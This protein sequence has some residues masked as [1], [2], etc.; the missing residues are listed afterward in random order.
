[1]MLRVPTVPNVPH[2]ADA[3][4]GCLACVLS[5]SNGDAERMLD[6]LVEADFHEQKHLTIFRL[7]LS[8]QLDSRPLTVLELVQLAKANFQ[9]DDC[10]GFEYLQRL[11]DASPS[12]ENFPTFNRTV[13]DFAARRDLLLQAEELKVRAWDTSRPADVDRVS[14]LREIL[15]QRS[16]DPAREPPKVQPV[17]ALLGQTVCTPE[18]L[19]TITAAVKAGKTAVIGAM[20]AAAFPHNHDADLLGFSSHNPDRKAIILIDSEQSPADHWNVCKTATRRAGSEKSPAWFYS[21]CL[22]GL[23][24]G[25]VWRLT[26]EAIR[27]AAE[28]HGGIHAIFLDGAADLVADVNDPAESNAFVAKLHGLAIEYHCPIVCA[29]HF[30]PGSEKSRGHLGSQLERKAESNLALEKDNDEI[31]VIY[32]TKQRRAPIPK[33]TGPRFRYSTEHGMHVSVES[34]AASKQELERQAL[35]EL[36]AD[37]FSERPSMRYCDLVSTVKTRLSVEPRTAERKI[38]HAVTLGVIKKSVARLYT[39][40]T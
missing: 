28:A 5:A 39:L 37:V 22:S 26:R 30:N 38:S 18:N 25:Q 21:Y 19:T 11:P 29:I 2:D 40:S 13:K 10:G 35:S 8:L 33:H 16:F 27:M 14:T 34:K 15:Q 23:D 6:E 24:C 3:E 32:S 9:L 36:F 7:L 31:T 20:A 17:F 12:P 4:A 1:M